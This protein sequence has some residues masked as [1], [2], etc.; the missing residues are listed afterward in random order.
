M[1]FKKILTGIDG[2]DASKEAA[3]EAIRVAKSV[4]ASLLMVYV[5]PMGSDMIEYFKVSKLKQALKENARKAMEDIRSEG[6]KQNIPVQVIIDEGSPSEKIIDIAVRNQCDLIV[7]GRKGKSALEKILVGS[8]AER[9]A[10]QSP[11]PVMLI[12]G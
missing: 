7:L 6:K 12:P 8:V 2:S 9:V 4:G 5:I 3:M 1:P 10:G 11:V